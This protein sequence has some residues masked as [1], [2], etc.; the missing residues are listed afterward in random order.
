M[1]VLD[2]SALLTLLFR[3]VGHERVSTVL[4][5]C[6]M[7]TVNLAEVLSRFTRDGHS[8]VQVLSLLEASPVE[9]VTFDSHHAALA[10]D[11]LPRTRHLGLSLGDRACLALAS[12]LGVPAMTADR[13]WTELDVG[14]EVQLIR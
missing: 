9:W 12:S 4:E 3:E 2:A 14:V 5:E 1:T 8:S 11:L 7:S 6:A 13:T 10:A